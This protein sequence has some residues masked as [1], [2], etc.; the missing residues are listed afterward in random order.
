MGVMNKM[1]VFNHERDYRRLDL[2]ILRKGA[3]ELYSNRTLLE[4]ACQW[5]R[6]ENYHVFVFQCAGWESTNDFHEAISNT[7]HFPDYYGLNLD[8]FNDC[9]AYIDVPQESGC[10]LVFYCFDLFAKKFPHF[11]YDVLDIIEIN[12]RRF[13]LYGERLIALL[14]SDDPNISFKPVGARSISLNQKRT[15]K[16]NKSQDS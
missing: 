15:L 6:G 10:L 8:A 13:L 12:S 9:L 2:N 3:I 16:T 7:L 1:A 14:Q 11:A 4:E 5:F